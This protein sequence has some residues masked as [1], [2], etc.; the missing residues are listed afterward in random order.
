M[1]PISL[2]NRVNTAASS[3]K[4]HS[5]TIATLNPLPRNCQHIAASRI[6]LTLNF[7]AQN[8]AFAFGVSDVRRLQFLWPCQKQP[9]TKIA[10]FRRRLARSG[11]PGKFLLYTQKLAPI[12]RTILR[13][14]ISAVVFCCLTALIIR[15]RTLGE[16][17]SELLSGLEIMCVESPPR[18]HVL[19][20]PAQAAENGVST[21]VSACTRSSKRHLAA[22]A[23]GTARSRASAVPASIHFSPH[24]RINDCIQLTNPLHTFRRGPK[25]R[26]ICWAFTTWTFHYHTSVTLQLRWSRAGRPPAIDMIPSL[27]PRLHLR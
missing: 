26:G 5:Q 18:L 12:A 2:C 25:M 27:E 19:Q 22:P 9:C 21:F 13:T 20:P 7:S 23:P 10:H 1:V 17:I 4:E 24:R 15:E 6:R 14:V 3:F 16:T 11:E 8:S